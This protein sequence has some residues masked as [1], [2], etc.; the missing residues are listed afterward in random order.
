MVQKLLLVGIFASIGALFGCKPRTADGV[1]NPKPA[2]VLLVTGIAESWSIRDVSKTASAK[3]ERTYVQLSVQEV[4]CEDVP[5]FS[6]K[7]ASPLSL[8]RSTVPQDKE[9][10]TGD[11]LRLTVGV[12]Q[13]P[14]PTQFYWMDT[15]RF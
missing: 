1:H 12:N 2:H 10:Q 4:K 5:G 9:I 14:N 8:N 11:R 7:L 13:L 15:E 3:N 6:E